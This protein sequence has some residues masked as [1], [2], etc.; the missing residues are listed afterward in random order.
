VQLIQAAVEGEGGEE[1][2]APDKEEGSPINSL[3]RD[4]DG[5]AIN[6]P[7]MAFSQLVEDEVRAARFNQ[8]LLLV[9]TSAAAFSSATLFAAAFSSL[10]QSL[11]GTARVDDAHAI[12]DII[13]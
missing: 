11:V 3:S 13:L 12:F 4:M 5:I 9:H 7:S 2:E 1:A 6:M 8:F 10:P